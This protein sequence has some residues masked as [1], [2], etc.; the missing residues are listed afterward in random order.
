MHERARSWYGRRH[1]AATQWPPAELAA[2]KGTTRISV[3]LPARDEERTVG[4]IVTAIREQLIRRWRLVEE[5]VVVDSGSRDRTASVAADAGARVVDQATVLPGIPVLP[6][7]GEALWRSLAATTGDL[8]LF[9]DADLTDLD[10]LRLAGLLGP[11]LTDP[12]VQLVKAA[13]DRPLQLGQQLL[14]AGGGRVT[15]LLARPLLN[16]YWPE[17]SGVVQPLA[18]EYAARRALLERLPFPTGYG[19]EVALLLDTVREFG[20]DAL[21]QVDLGRRSHRHHSDSRL[22]AMASEIL[23]AALRRLPLDGGA[24][25]PDPSEE[26]VSFARSNGQYRPHTTTVAPVERPPM[27]S[28][29]R[30]R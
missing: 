10:P 15:E 17:L 8:I 26:L 4:A 20:L 5:I 23:Q 29:P 14:P 13:Y 7:K 1:S 22:A 6:G 3:V 27:V 25:W 19:V 2:A 16:L 24:R 12:G 21:A 11:L 30:Q 18:G 28:L 9:C